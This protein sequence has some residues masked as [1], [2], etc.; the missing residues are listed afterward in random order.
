MSK[1]RFK[2]GTNVVKTL[3]GLGGY[4]ETSKGVVT[5]VSKGV[6]YVDDESGI[7]FDAITGRELENFFP[8]M[9]Q[10]IRPE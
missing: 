5:K 3:Y 1:T 10:E 4:M 6:V 7:T 2:K 9:R 8:P